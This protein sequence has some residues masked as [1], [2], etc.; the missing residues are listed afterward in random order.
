MHP[1]TKWMQKRGRESPSSG[2]ENTHH[3]GDFSTYFRNKQIKLDNQAK[4]SIEQH[5][6]I[7]AGCVIYIT[8]YTVPSATQL[9]QLVVANGGQICAML[10]GKTYATHIV[11]TSL[12]ARKREQYANYTVVTPQWVV[13]C[14]RSQKRLDWTNYSLFN[15]IHDRV[16]VS[17]EPDEEVEQHGGHQHYGQQHDRQQH[18]GQQHG[19]AAPPEAQTD[20]NNE[21]DMSLRSAQIQ[22]ILDQRPRVDCT[23]PNFVSDYFR[24]SRLHFLSTF[25]LELRKRCRAYMED[26]GL[27]QVSAPPGQAPLNRILMHV[28]FDSFFVAVA[29]K[30][31]PH[32]TD[33]PVC[34]SHG[35]TGSDVASCN[36]V[37]RKYG[38]KNGMWVSG[39][40]EL[41]PQLICLPYDFDDYKFCSQ[42]LYDVLLGLKPQQIVAISVDEAILDVSKNEYFEQIKLLPNETQSDATV[43]GLCTFVRTQ[44][45]T[46]AGIDASIGVGSNVLLCKLALK[47]AKP[48]GQHEI[49]DLSEVLDMKVNDLPGVGYQTAHKLREMECL[50]IG[51]LQKVPLITL[52]TE[53]GTAMGHKLYGYALGTDTVNLEQL[54]V[55]LQSVGL[56]IGWGVRV[57]N[58]T[59]QDIFVLNCVSELYDRIEQADLKNTKNAG[60]GQ[61]TVKIHKRSP[62]AHFITTKYMGHGHCEVTSRGQVIPLKLTL[63]QLQQATREMVREIV[64]LAR[65]EPLEF[66][67]LGLHLKVKP[68]STRVNNNTLHNYF[69]LSSA[70]GTYDPATAVK[71]PGLSP[72]TI[73]SPLQSPKTSPKKQ[74]YAVPPRKRSKRHTLTQMVLPSDHFPPNEDI[75]MDVLAELPEHIQQEVLREVHRSGGS[76]KRKQLESTPRYQPKV[77]PP[78]YSSPSFL[79]LSGAELRQVLRDWVSSTESPSLEDIQQFYTYACDAV[80]RSRWCD[81]LDLIDWLRFCCCGRGQWLSEDWRIFYETLDARIQQLAVVGVKQ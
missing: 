27:A 10:G 67:G 31:R 40:K 28:D 63:E 57:I 48:A 25:K 56:D 47:I 80:R 49:K 69:S 11:A 61:Y 24:N 44:I 30:K 52:Q 13:D 32:L 55:P 1:F 6:S 79:G 22:W 3:N 19:V 21:K 51:D 71:P 72:S 8:G 15:N 2:A 41:C 37:A 76:A 26:A 5:S 62:E 73:Q 77:E 53:L 20:N 66:R 81:T 46:S 58:K 23:Q 39:A 59:E 50:T 12:T 38:V 7:F 78:I 75:D 14:A 4:D 45:K 42:R 29:L 70:A 35:G 17:V 68:G 60:S 16:E 43:E 9:K 33:K 74:M 34:V 54:D 64:E 36:Y 65:C 18:D